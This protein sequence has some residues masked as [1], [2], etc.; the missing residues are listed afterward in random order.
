MMPRKEAIII[1]IKCAAPEQFFEPFF[2]DIPAEYQAMLEARAPDGIPCEGTGNIGLW[3]T[4]RCPW[5]EWEES[6]E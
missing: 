4:E 5:A 6:H 2:Q 1:D 3:C